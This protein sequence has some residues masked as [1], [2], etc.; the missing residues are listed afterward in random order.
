MVSGS[1]SLSPPRRVERGGASRTI[2][3]AELQR[4]SVTKDEMLPTRLGKADERAPLILRRNL[5]HIASFEY[6]DLT[7][8]LRVTAEDGACDTGV[9]AR[10]FPGDRLGWRQGE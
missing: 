4:S 6:F 8:N 9:V 5:H 2:V 10:G 7:S 3:S 1:L